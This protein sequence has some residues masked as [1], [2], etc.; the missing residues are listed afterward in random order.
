MRVSDKVVQTLTKIIAFTLMTAF[1]SLMIILIDNKLIGYL[2]DKETY[3]E[4]YAY[5]ESFED[6]FKVEDMVEEVSE[7][8]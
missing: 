1:A 5:T 7:Q 4:V 6:T 3:G 2:T 8:N